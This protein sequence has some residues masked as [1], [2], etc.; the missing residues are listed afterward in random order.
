MRWL[1]IKDL[2][3]LRRSPLLV[4]LLVAYPV[5]LSLMVGVALSSPPGKPAV[6]FLDE[7]APGHG[8]VVF[9][10]RRLDVGSLAADLLG[11]IRPLRVHTL[12]AAIADVRSGRALAAVVI[13]A[14]LPAQIRGLLSEGVGSPT[15]QVYLNTANPLERELVD[16]A[17]TTRLAQIQQDVSRQLLRVAVGDLHEVLDGGRVQILGQSV[18]LLGLRDAREI[19]AGAVRALPPGSALRAALAQ[20]VAF[21]DLAVEGLSFAGPVLGSIGSPLVVQ[22]FQLAGAPTPAATYAASIAVVVSLMLVAMLLAAGLLSVERSENAYARLA[23]GLVAPRTV[24]ASKVLLA[25]GLAAGMALAMAAGI[26]AFV[27]LSWGRVELWVL[28]LAIGGLSFAALGAALGALARDVSAA[29]LLAVSVSLP[30]AFLALVPAGAVSPSLSRA[31]AVVSFLLP[32]RAALEAASRA[33]TAGSPLPAVAHL[34]AL[35]LAFG[36]AGALAM[37]RLRPSGLRSG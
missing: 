9:A 36:A 34:A 31:L 12:A 19:V 24:L 35:A 21:A 11:S 10:G 37:R 20:V 7:V 32:F 15:V 1:L 6:A 2:Q 3:I 25:G 27:T 8:E 33:F 28:S 26:S 13:P 22:R 4:G 23:R 18:A 14:D 30:V 29:S 5:A 17:L 16:Q